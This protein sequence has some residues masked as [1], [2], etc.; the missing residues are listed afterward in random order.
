MYDSLNKHIHFLFKYKMVRVQ[1]YLQVADNTGAQKVMCIRLMNSASQQASVG[2]IIVVVV[3][4]R[5]L[6]NLVS[7]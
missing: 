1:T 6:K 7:K 5:L 3:K 2:D 4:L